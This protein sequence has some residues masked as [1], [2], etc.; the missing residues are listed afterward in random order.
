[1]D[2]RGK[3]PGERRNRNEPGRGIS[4]EPCIDE[5]KSSMSKLIESEN[6]RYS[7]KNSGSEMNLDEK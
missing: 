3:K 4:C 2:E 7:R 6:E 1:M 5:V